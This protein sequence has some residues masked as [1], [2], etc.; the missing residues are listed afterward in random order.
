MSLL[1]VTGANQEIGFETA[2]DLALSG[3]YHVI[4]SSRDTAKGEVAVKT[5]QSLP[6]I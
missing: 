3:N 6:G 2:K 4:L 5:L 1:T